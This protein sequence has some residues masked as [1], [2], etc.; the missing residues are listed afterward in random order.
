MN[1]FRI[2][3]IVLMG[4]M[5]LSTQALAQQ[6]ALSAIPSVYDNI[7]RDPAGR[8]YVEYSGIRYYARDPQ[9]RYRLA[10]MK[11][12]PIGTDTGIDFDFGDD[13]FSGTLYIGLIPYGDSKHPLPV[14]FARSVTIEAGKAS[15]DIKNWFK[16]RYDMIGWEASGKGTLGYRVANEEGM[17]LY[18]GKVSF[19][20]TGPFEIDVTV[21]EGP[22][23]H[24]PTMEGAT[25]SFET[26]QPIIAHVEVEGRTF[27]DSTATRRHEITITG[28]QAGTAYAYTIRYGDNAQT[29]A[30]KTVPKPGSRQ[31]FTFSYSS[32]SRS[33]QGGGERDLYGANFYIVKRI[34]ALNMLKEVAFAQFSG[35]LIDGYLDLKWEE[36]Y[37]FEHTPHPIEFQ[38]YYSV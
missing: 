35:D 21:T 36:V 20:G 12:D 9:P 4:A 32:D 34:M 5:T 2:I 23:V 3:L 30:F 7:E 22:F 19:R 28:L 31:P 1:H 38:M 33:G 25:I 24:I 29:Y 26:N 13:S 27:S 18:D 16:G 10:Q 14:Y 6:T 37:A 8:L 11:G 15:V 17:L